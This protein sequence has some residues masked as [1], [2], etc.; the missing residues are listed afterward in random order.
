MS[1]PKLGRGSGIIAVN[2][3]FEVGGGGRTAQGRGLAKIWFFKKEMLNQNFSSYIASEMLI[4][5]T[6]GVESKK[7]SHF[8]WSGSESERGRGRTN[9]QRSHI[10]RNANVEEMVRKQLLA[11]KFTL[12]LRAE[13]VYNS[14]L[15]ELV[16]H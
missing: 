9:I 5:I 3:P 12:F 16:S 4:Y 11:L 7:K 2:W 8:A 13:L 15:S 14:P 6:A 1:A 10:I